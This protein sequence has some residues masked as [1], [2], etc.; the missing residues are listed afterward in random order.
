MM[1]PHDTVEA[2]ILEL[3]AEVSPVT[4]DQIRASSDFG[5]LRIDSV[6]S[7]ELVGLICDEYGIDVEIEEAFGVGTVQE[8]VD[9]TMRHL[10]PTQ[11]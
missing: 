2:R 3:V 8:A 9:L 7:M 11:P 6:G 10:N 4:R 5:S 1:P